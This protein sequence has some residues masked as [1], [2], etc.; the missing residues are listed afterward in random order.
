MASTNPPNP[1]CLVQRTISVRP[2]T[3]TDGFEVM[4]NKHDTYSIEC[5]TL[6]EGI[7]N[8]YISPQQATMARTMKA[9]RIAREIM[10]RKQLQGNTLADIRQELSN[11]SDSLKV[12]NT[13]RADVEINPIEPG[14]MIGASKDAFSDKN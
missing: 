12:P 11:L 5:G 3:T 7:A 2:A 10:A 4:A 6:E 9:R 13:P 1:L 14:A 8:G